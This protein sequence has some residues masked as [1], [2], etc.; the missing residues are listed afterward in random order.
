MFY[1][2]RLVEIFQRSRGGQYM[3]EVDFDLLLA[4]RTQELVK[5]YN[6]IYD[7]GNV[8]PADDAMADRVFQA[9]LQL[10]VDVGTYHLDTQRVI[11]FTRE[12]ILDALRKAPDT[13]YLG[14]GRDMVIAKHRNIEDPNP[15]LNLTG[16]AG[17]PCSEEHYLE[18]MISYAQEPYVHAIE[19]GA[20]LTYNGADIMANT[21]LEVKAV[22]RDAATA[23]EAIRRVGKPGMHIGDAATGMTAI[24]KMAASEPVNLLRPCDGTTWWLRCASSRLTMTS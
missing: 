2:D 14:E 7:P 10:F 13:L 4:R 12:E 1:N 11:K 5:E 15:P 6:I 22:Q 9:G 21:L 3:K 24:G 23:R 8:C 19:S 20:T 16:P 18:L 17:Q